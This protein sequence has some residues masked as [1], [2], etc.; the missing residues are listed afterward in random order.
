[1]CKYPSEEPTQ[2]KWSIDCCLEVEVDDDDDDDDDDGD[3][4]NDSQHILLV[5]CSPG[6]R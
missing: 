4:G 1:M 2:R 5:K 3:W 6:S